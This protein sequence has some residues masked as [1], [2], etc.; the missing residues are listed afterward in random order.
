M[1]AKIPESGYPGFYFRRRR[2]GTKADLIITDPEL[3]RISRRERMSP[4][5]AK[6]LLKNCPASWFF[7]KAFGGEELDFAATTLG[8]ATHTTLEDFYGLPGHE[9]AYQFLLERIIELSHER[10]NGRDAEEERGR[11]V[12]TVMSYTAP[13]LQI[14]MDPASI[15]ILA[16]ELEVIGEVDGVPFICYIDRVS[17]S[18][19]GEVE[20]VDYKS[21]KSVYRERGADSNSDQIV[22]NAVF[23]EAVDH[24]LQPTAG[25]FFYTRRGEVTDVDLSRE[26]KDAARKMLV[27]AWSSHNRFHD[28]GK[29]PTNVSGLC[30]GCPLVN[31]CP[32][33]QAAGKTSKDFRSTDPLEREHAV[34]PV[35]DFDEEFDLSLVEPERQEEPAV[36]HEDENPAHD[37]KEPPMAP[38]AKTKASQATAQALTPIRVNPKP[39]DLLVV[40]DSGQEVL[41]P[42]AFGS[43]TL[44]G[45]FSV[46][47]KACRA[48]VSED[49]GVT[50]E[51]LESVY[52]TVL[53]VIQEAQRAWVG[54]VDPQHGAFTR[55]VGLLHTQIESEPIPAHE[56]EELRAWAESTVEFLIS[57]VTLVLDTFDD[58][59]SESEQP[60]AEPWG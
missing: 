7:G 40:D 35:L 23:L 33:A 12:R 17:I 36:H 58:P 39:Y 30:G 5:T 56:P 21:S 46:S 49:E 29:F 45:L 48:S 2:T 54:T 24:D 60:W 44:F 47:L 10:F 28:Q 27:K 19:T 9:R 6:S 38:K 16:R 52:R 11:W 20:I 59:P 3:T 34:I 53:W 26:A 13:I 32:S 22:L 42:T 57:C 25:R 4:S 41:N 15:E 8:K 43:A 37:T 14:D 55:L 51:H 1:T 18:P 31:H 50:G